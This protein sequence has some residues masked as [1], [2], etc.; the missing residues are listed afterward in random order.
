MLIIFDWDGTLMDSAGKIVTAMQ[1]AAEDVGCDV[2][3]DVAIRDIIGLGLPEAIHALYPSLDAARRERVR[4]CYA[5]RFVALDAIPSRLFPGVEETL[6]SLRD[7]GHQLAIATGKS[8]RGL[9]RVLPRTGLAPLFEASRCADE[10]RSKPDPRMLHELLDACG[11][12][13]M[14]SVMV[15]DSTYDMRMAESIGMARVAVSYGV[16][17]PEQLA[18]H[19]PV[20]CVDRL[21][22]LLGWV[23]EQGT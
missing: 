12:P 6:L 1:Q 2:L 16:H 21:P 3:E 10:T 4:Q 5:E 14:E 18:R 20:R 17:S 8:R 23:R 9:E 11:A 13:L 19:T 7:E 15:G 22:Q